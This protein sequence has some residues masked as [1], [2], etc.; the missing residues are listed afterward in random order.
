MYELEYVKKRKR[1][2]IIALAGGV[3]AI[4][5]ITFVIIAF[6]G[7]FVGTFTVSL[8]TRNVALM[9][10]EKE[11]FEQSSSFL[12]VNSV[13]TFEEF[14]YSDLYTKY[15]GDLALDT[16]ATTITYGANY[17]KDGETIKSLNFFK[18]T[19]YV[20]NTGTQ[21]AIYDFALNILENARSADGRSLDDTLRI[22]VYEEGEKTVY[23]KPQSTP[24]ID[25][26]GNPDYRAP[27]SVAKEDA[28]EEYPFMGYAEAFVSPSVVT[29]SSSILLEVGV[30]KRYTVVTW[31]EGFRSSSEQ[32]APQGATIKLGVE[33]NAYEIK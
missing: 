8:E 9:L 30:S 22:I 17:N 27:I 20:K 7:R 28:T 5:V 23:A 31:L 4:V 32:E 33:I 29:T 1:R 3:S 24:R 21:A 13:A 14:T 19:F 26:Q 12:R 6:L 2:R 10:S 11:S 16:E 15:G 25:E 18:Y